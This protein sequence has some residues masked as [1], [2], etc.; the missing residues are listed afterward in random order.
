MNEGRVESKAAGGGLVR[1]R[2]AGLVEVGAL[3]GLVS[4]VAISAVSVSG[5]KVREIFGGS[6]NALALGMDGSLTGGVNLAG[7][8]SGV[9][10][11]PVWTT[12]SGQVGTV[13][14]G[15]SSGSAIATL[16][17]TDADGNVLSYAATSLP[18]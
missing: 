11:P 17:A 6:A 9:N 13:R 1:R 5:G 15:A 3:I 12:A 16:S 14:P 10:S 18:S 2:G 8:V 4:V 7:G